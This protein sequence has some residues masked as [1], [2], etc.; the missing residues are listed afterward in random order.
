[1]FDQPGTT[2][3]VVTAVTAFDGWPVELADTAGLRQSNESI[4]RIGVSLS[5][6][7]IA[8]AGLVVLVHDASNDAD[9]VSEPPRVIAH[10]FLLVVNKIDLRRPQ[11]IKSALPVSAVTGEGIERLMSAIARRLV[12]DPP[13]RGEAVPFAERQ[14]A[15]LREALDSLRGGDAAAAVARLHALRQ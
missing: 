14:I 1:V 11:D 5:R 4:E 3:D 8:A 7:Q 2:R 15:L 13:Q 6:E 10:R 9:V 12:P